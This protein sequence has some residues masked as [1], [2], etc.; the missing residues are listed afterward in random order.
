MAALTSL[1]TETLLKLKDYP[2]K[3]VAATAFRLMTAGKTAE[4]IALLQKKPDALK[5]EIHPGQ[6]LFEY[7]L[8]ANLKCAE[9]IAKAFPSAAECKAA[10]GS[11]L[12][13]RLAAEGNRRLFLQV[14]DMGANLQARDDDNNTIMHYAALS[15]GVDVMLEAAKLGIGK[16]PVNN[17]GQTPLMHLSRTDKKAPGAVAVYLSSG[18]KLNSIDNNGLN[19]TMHAMQNLRLDLATDLMNAGGEVDFNQTEIL[20]EARALAH[21][22]T[23]GGGDFMAA[24]AQRHGIQ[25]A[26]A[27]AERDAKEVRE[28]AAAKAVVD[29]VDSLRKGTTRA[30]KLKTVKFKAPGGGAPVA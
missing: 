14:A 11:T 1:F 16:N 10:G 4:G 25:T 22:Q 12:L 24:L 23:V 28:A 13:M 19:P 27:A 2:P 6:T 21:K 5:E 15:D 20:V 18:F 7:M 8:S 26:D 9:K 30:P 3:D 17:F 29:V